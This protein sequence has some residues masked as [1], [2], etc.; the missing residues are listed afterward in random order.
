[1][2]SEFPLLIQL[3]LAVSASLAL[4][5]WIVSV[6]QAISSKQN[7]IFAIVPATQPFLAL[8]Q[9]FA[10][11]RWSKAPGLLL[12]GALILFGFGPKAVESLERSKLL[13]FVDQVE[14]KGYDTDFE[15]RVSQHASIPAEQNSWR[16]P[17]LEP[18][19]LYAKH[20]SSG[21]SGSLL[22]S[23]AQKG[24]DRYDS[25]T[26]KEI[27]LR[28]EYEVDSYTP[29]ISKIYPIRRTLEN[30]ARVLYASNLNSQQ[31]ELPKELKSVAKV[32]SH[33]YDGLNEYFDQFE[34]AVSREKSA[35]YYNLDRGPFRIRL[36]HLEYIKQIA[37]ALNDR[38]M[39]RLILGEQEAAWKDWKTLSLLRNM[40]ESD[41][42][43]LITLLVQLSHYQVMI[44]SAHAAQALG[45]WDV[46]KWDQIETE[47]ARWD[48]RKKVIAA[49]K[50]EVA[51]LAAEGVYIATNSPKENF[52]LQRVATNVIDTKNR[53]SDSRLTKTMA[54]LKIDFWSQLSPS[55]LRALINSEIRSGLSKRFSEIEDVIDWLG[56]GEPGNDDDFSKTLHVPIPANADSELK[57]ESSYRVYEKTLVLETRILIAR[58][59]CRLETYR[60][61]NGNY[62]DSLEL[63]QQSGLEEI[64][65]EKIGEQGFSL[66][67][68]MPDWFSDIH[69]VTWKIDEQP[70]TLPEYQL[71]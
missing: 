11:G 36:P 48:A 20:L 27:P 28:F 68:N 54:Y 25:L 22:A 64:T 23:E 63:I 13:R 31:S 6:V 70:P 57:P 37:F 61:K 44:E 40:Q 45:A 62:P 4:S 59:A 30:S 2:I 19:Y 52:D 24:L 35:Y 46:E 43:M 33:F 50:M 26:P 1:M 32:M 5:S 14:A 66:S 29:I 60:M 51:M 56:I 55:T 7:Y 69:E 58:V 65:Y 12:I 8:V 10:K 16:S 39:V 34:E 47:F 15:S 41:L 21:E 3:T 17:F 42:E 49:L 9:L 18:L 71:F 38:M 53:S 67:I